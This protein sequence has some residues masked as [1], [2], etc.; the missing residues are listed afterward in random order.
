[1]KR[2][3]NIQTPLPID[4]GGTGA[5][6]AADAIANLG[7]EVSAPGDILYT[8]RDSP[9]GYIPADGSIVLQSAYPDLF[10]ETGLLG[11]TPGFSPL[12]DVTPSFT[13]FPPPGTNWS[14]PTN[15]IYSIVYAL[16]KF[17]AVGVYGILW[18][19]PDGENWTD[20]GN[21][22][23]AS[24]LHDIEFLNNTL[25][26]V[27]E[28]STI[29]TSSDGS[30]WTA[31]SASGSGIL[32]GIAY[33]NSL[34]VV[35]GR[36]GTILTSPDLTTWT[37]QTT[38]SSID[39]TE[40]AYGNGVFVAS[41]I[42]GL[43]RSTNG[44]NW[45]EVISD[46][47]SNMTLTFGDGLFVI[48]RASGGASDTIQTST[49]GL[50]WTTPTVMDH[51]P[52]IR[53]LIFSDGLFLG[54]GGRSSTPYPYTFH[55]MIWYSNDGVN[56]SEYYLSTTDHQPMFCLEAFDGVVVVGGRYGA[57]WTFATETFPYNK[58]TEFQ[59]PDMLSAGDAP[60]W[61]KI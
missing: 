4:K 47:N 23:G 24:T 19:S 31:Q 52:T 29:L 41:G 20:H 16:G 2:Q 34:Y 25:V 36:D 59:V 26:T 15:S 61:V 18:S 42:G 48:G 13:T 46:A 45:I 27:G 43:W 58:L 53:K 54:V 60:A 49:D 5:T 1:M 50:T 44:V 22:N 38:P 33:G 3:P 35:C 56:W 55:E 40:V 39:L 30:S 9:A 10:A 12:Q 14:P 11:G 28:S 37:T 51:V 8:M 6:Q 32:T 57:I 7:L 21:L 17:F